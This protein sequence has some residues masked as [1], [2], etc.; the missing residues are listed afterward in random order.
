MAPYPGG[1]VPAVGLRGIGIGHADVEPVLADPTPEE[2]RDILA[3][4]GV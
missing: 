3:N 1:P 4:N 2:R